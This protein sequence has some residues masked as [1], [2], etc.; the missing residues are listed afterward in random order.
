MSQTAHPQTDS[1]NVSSERGFDLQRYWQVLLKRKW[2]V[3]GA[4]VVIVA[5]VAVWTF[6]QTR[7]YRAKASVLVERQAP[8]VLGKDVREVVDLSMG[9]FWRNKEYMETQQKVL[10]SK[11]LSLKV[12]Q[13]LALHQNQRFWPPKDSG[14]HSLDETAERLK[15][16]IKPKAVR[17]ANIIEIAVSH[18]DPELAAKLANAVVSQYLDYNVEYRLSSTVGAVKW[19]ADQL[20]DIQKKLESSEKALHH[21][22]KKNNIVSVSLEDK[23]TLLARKIQRINDE[24]TDVQLKLRALRAERK[25]LTTALKS[26]DPTAII[27]NDTIKLLKKSLIRSSRKLAELR[28]NYLGKHPLVRAQE[29]K[30]EAIRAD[31]KHEV[32]SALAST[33]AKVKKLQDNERSIATALQKAKNEALD[34]NKRELD[35]RRLKRGQENNAKLYSAILSRLKEADLSAQLRVNNIR[36]L[37]AADVPKFPVKPKVKLILAIAGL[38]GLLFGI[39]L[40]LLIDMLDSTVKTQEEVEA[41]GKLVFLGLLPRI[42]GSSPSKKGRR[43]DPRPDLDLIVHRTPKSSVAESCRVIRTNLLFTSPDSPM[44]KLLIT[45]PGPREGKTTTAVSLAIAMAQSGHRILLIDTDMRRPRLHRVFSVP[46]VEGITSV[47]LGDK[48]IDAMIK[49]TEIPNLYVLPCGPTPPNPAELCHSERF[50]WLLSELEQRFDRVLLDSPPVMAVTDAVVLS[51]LVDGAIVVA[52]A[53]HTGRFALR[54]TVRQISDV[55]GVRIGC[56]LNDMDLEHRAYG[57]YRYRRYGY[58]YRGYGR[59]YGEEEEAAQ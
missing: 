24:L 17:H 58:N 55:G 59:Y 29:A 35:Y 44:S 34:I 25:Q 50:K 33:T 36:A 16:L 39:A 41:S 27:K 38:F 43:P 5:A 18:H 30:V 47:L 10:T 57:Y 8:Q 51:T 52:R 26:A 49:S 1:S 45:S 37:D 6:G 4:C 2:L 12:A 42:P 28:S 20:D 21:F 23:Q 7:I 14:K 56:V 32:S 15:S 40:A 46:G 54:E 48:T 31:I 9:S 53:G 13:H 11:A 19:L 22:K 3:L